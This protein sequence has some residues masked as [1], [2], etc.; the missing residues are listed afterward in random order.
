MGI[1]VFL[2]ASDTATLISCVWAYVLAHYFEL[3]SFIS[4]EEVLHRAKEGMRKRSSTVSCTPI[5]FG[6][7][8]VTPCW[9][10]D[11]N[12]H[13]GEIIINTSIWPGLARGD[14]IQVTPAGEALHPGTHFLFFVDES[15]TNN[16]KI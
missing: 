1:I 8:K 16:S 6:Q 2:G 15:T 9:I 4:F 7:H 13:P 3:S 12:F 5:G 14:L 10:H 11:Q